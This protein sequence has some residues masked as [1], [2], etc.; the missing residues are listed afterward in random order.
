M[1]ENV[2]FLAIKRF[3]LQ[4]GTTLAA[5]SSFYFLLTI[6]PMTL[7]FV[8]G[9]GYVLGDLSGALEQVFLVISSFF[10]KLTNDFLVA[11]KELVSTALFG[12]VKLTIINFIFLLLII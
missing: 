4:R 8:R 6:V 11:I 1:K 10:P 9:I 7:I 3:N 2:L 5:A 12:P